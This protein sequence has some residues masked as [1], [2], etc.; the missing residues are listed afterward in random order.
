MITLPRIKSLFKMNRAKMVNGKLLWAERLYSKSRVEVL[1]LLTPRDRHIVKNRQ[2]TADHFLTLVTRLQAE[3]Y[4]IVQE[5]KVFIY[6]KRHWRHLN[7]IL[8]L[9]IIGL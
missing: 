4:H 8:A 3:F 9:R 1:G 7:K 6:N 5:M 2:T